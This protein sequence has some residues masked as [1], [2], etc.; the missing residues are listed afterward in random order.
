MKILNRDIGPGRRPY[1]LA[2]MS[3]NHNQS[4]ER[5]LVIVDATAAHGADAIKLQTNTAD[6]IERDV[7]MPSF[8]DSAMDFLMSLNKMYRHV[9][10]CFQLNLRVADGDEDVGG[11]LASDLPR[12]GVLSVAHE[13]HDRPRQCLISTTARAT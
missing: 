11:H 3:G 7:L 9:A 5:A 6:T 8:D 2:E 13:A 12:H 1:L 4:L 10:R